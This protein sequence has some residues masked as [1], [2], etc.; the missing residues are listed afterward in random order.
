M[1][2]KYAMKLILVCLIIILPYDFGLAAWIS[3]NPSAKEG[4]PPLLKILESTDN[5]TVISIEIPGFYRE[6]MTAN[7]VIFD[8][9]TIPQAAQNADVGSPNIPR[10]L[11]NI[12]IPDQAGITIREVS[13]ETEM[14]DHIMVIPV[15]QPETDNATPPPFTMNEALYGSDKVYPDPY[16]VASEPQIWRDVRM[17]TA[18]IYPIQVMPKSQ[19]ISVCKSITIELVYNGESSINKKKSRPFRIS[20]HY[21]RMY[22][23]S[24]LNYDQLNLPKETQRDETTKYLIIAHDSLVSSIQPLADWWTR[25]GLPVEIKPT[26]EIGST[27]TQI[28]EEISNYYND[29]GIEFVLLV[30]ETSQIPVFSFESAVGDHDYACLEGSDF[31]PDVALG[32][33]LT[34]SPD[35]VSHI[36]AR[37]LN[38][39]QSPPQDGWLERTMLCAHEEEYP[40]KYTQCKNEIR[41]YSYAIQTPVFETYYPPEGATLAQ[42]TAAME[43][44]RGLINYRGHGDVMEW[45]WS[46]GWDPSNIYDLNNGRYTPIVWNICCNNAWIDSSNETISEAWQNAGSSGEGGAVANLGATRESYTVENHDFDKR[47]YRALFDEGT[48]QIGDVVNL[49]KETM[50]NMGENGTY[51]ARIYILFGDP[52]LDI[53]TMDPASMQVEH[54]PSIPI[55]GSEF[56][57]AVSNDSGTPLEN[58]QVCIQKDGECYEAGYTDSLG[59]LSLP[60]LVTSGGTLALTITAHNFIPYTADVSVEAAGC[61]ALLLD[62]TLYNCDQSVLVRV[63]DSDLNLDP[64]VADT[65]SVD[66]SSDSESIPETLTLTETG[67]DTSEFRGII[68]TSASESSAGYLLLSN[69]DTIVVDYHDED[70]D[71]A[72]RVIQDTSIADCIAPVISNLTISQL[73]LDTATITWNTNERADAMIVFGESTP[74]DTE[75]IESRMLTEHSLTLTDL[76]VCTQYFFKV[77]SMDP[78]GNRVE[79]DN[80]GSY[81]TFTTL[82]LMILLENNMDNDPGWSYTG[83]WAW[84]HPTGSSGDPSSGHSGSNVVGYNLNGSYNDNLSAQYT[85]TPPFDCSGASQAYLSF[86]KWLGIESS[87]YDHAT[88]EISVNGGSIWNTIWSHSSGSVNPNEWS[89]VEYDISEW[90]AG[91]SNV[92]LR[93]SMGPTDGSV[94]YCG[95]NIDDVMVSYTTA[96]NV[97]ILVHGSHTIDDSEG[98]NDGQI[99]AGETIV[100]GIVLE[101]QGLSGTG[102]TASIQTSNPHIT[103]LSGYSS[104]PDIPQGGH[105]QSIADYRFRVSPEAADGEIILFTISWMANENSGSSA[106]QEI[107]AAPSLVIHS[108]SLTELTGS[109]Y[110][111]IWD[112][113]ETIRLVINVANQGSGFAHDVRGTITTDMPSFITINDGTAEFGDIIQGESSECTASCFTL[114]ADSSIPDH[115]IVSITLDLAAIGYISNDIFQMEVTHSNY[116]RRL[117]WNMDTNPGWITEGQWAWG[118]PAGASGDPAGGFTGT[119]VYGYNLNGTYPNNLPETTLTSTPIDCS[120]Y[121]NVHVAFMR[122][123]G[124]ESATWDHASFRVSNNGSTWTTIWSHTGSTFTDPTWQDLD[125]DI[126]TVADGQSTV[127]LRWVMGTTDS[128]VVYCGWNIDDVELWAESDQSIPTPTP[129]PH[130]LCIH[131]GDVNMNGSITA[132]DAQM[133]FQIT[134]G[135]YIPDYTEECAADC[136]GNGAITAG[137]AQSIFAA[138]LGLGSCVDPMDS[139]LLDSLISSGR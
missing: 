114:T 113:G 72:P 44:G 99:N 40:G 37:T 80:E 22:Q 85:T 100:M 46:I 45:S 139:G 78:S 87:S 29:L 101:N 42:V 43:Q 1:N 71:G 3:I 69:G 118:Q 79:D 2:S 105:G 6:K 20:P 10:L 77:V 135:V 89:Y 92:M 133:A 130:P 67:S 111:G 52:A 51:N 119:N 47:L 26:S 60:T 120:H 132:G 91:Q 16:V 21:D 30:G 107:V 15:Q 19:M 93:W 104:Y 75:L 48:T 98:N 121:Q 24:I 7:G 61:G 112:P 94:T 27:T 81:Y 63:W 5:H 88:V 96:C 73:G 137:D 65:C 109:D 128:S 23:H 66:I 125:Y 123:L 32:R 95:W 50:I 134:L 70:C 97:P 55:G 68:Q 76:N 35:I 58:A 9:V 117:M 18:T 64:Q 38:Y 82:Q 74:P 129:T 57:V 36:V 4:S 39:I 62:S 115:S 53:T 56:S 86:W 90:A 110:D 136:N 127:Y 126:S 14:I 11:V 41:N 12:G 59:R 102:V 116:A 34:T 25:T 33:I 49:A 131:D 31:Y 106:F 103:I 13:K 138:T 124:I 122:W 54:L 28:K 8:E 17:V 84:G 83:Q 108:H